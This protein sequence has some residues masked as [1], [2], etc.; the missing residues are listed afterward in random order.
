M[1]T[2][3]QHIVNA[4]KTNAKQKEKDKGRA[5]DHVAKKMGTN[6][7][8]VGQAE[9]VQKKANELLDYVKRNELSLANARLL[10]QKL[11]NEEDRLT[12]FH[13]YQK[14]E[15]KMQS[16]VDDI[17]FGNDPAHEVG[18][19]ELNSKPNSSISRKI[20]FNMKISKAAL[21]D[22]KDVLY[23]HGYSEEPYQILVASNDKEATEWIEPILEG[24]NASTTIYEV[25]P[26]SAIQPIDQ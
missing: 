25:V 5:L 11:T 4:I 16:I 14:G 15:G 12:A 26:E 23:K 1:R 3:L 21:E 17:L 18:K 2:D 9:Y 10:A 22:I 19:G 6:R 7:S 20:V 13:K 24:D 8:Y